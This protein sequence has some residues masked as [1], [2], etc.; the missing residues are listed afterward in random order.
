MILLPDKW[1]Y[2]STMKCATNS[3]YK[4]L[5]EQVDGAVWAGGNNF[6]AI[7]SSMSHPI[8]VGGTRHKKSFMKKERLAPLHWTVV[9]NPF[10]RAVSIWASTCVRESSRV[11]YEPFDL[12]TEAGGDPLNFEDFVDHILIAQPPLRVPWLY[13]NQ[14]DWIDQFICDKFL[15]L[16]YLQPY[17][18]ELLGQPIKL[19]ME[20]TSDHQNYA[21]YYKT[22][23]LRNK[24]Q[25]EWAREDCLRYYYDPARLLC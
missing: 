10:A 20:N 3:L 18:E 7:P 1:L 5:R 23:E 4:D 12:I 19:S 16:E 22:V 11:N 15:Q 24:V 6:H 14:S 13:R 21:S 2:I 8:P 25:Y 17:L 9:R